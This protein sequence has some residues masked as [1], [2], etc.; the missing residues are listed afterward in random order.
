MLLRER[1]QL[2]AAR[3]E[4]GH[5]HARH[6]DPQFRRSS[7]RRRYRCRR[8]WYIWNGGGYGKLDDHHCYY[9]WISCHNSRRFGTGLFWPLHLGPLSRRSKF[10]GLNVCAV[11]KVSFSLT[12]FWITREGNARCVD[13]GAD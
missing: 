7:H 6:A 12:L 9:H 8:S 4:M 3:Q 11:G 10:F 2:E 1:L 5:G 13:G